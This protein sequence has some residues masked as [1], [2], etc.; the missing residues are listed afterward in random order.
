MY[1][2]INNK[3]H[4]VEAYGEKL[5]YMSNGYPRL[6]DIN[7]A[8]PTDMVTVAEVA[9]VPEDMQVH[10]YCYTDEGGFTLNPDWE[11]PNGYGIPEELLRQ[12]KDDTIAEV[13]GAVLNGID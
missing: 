8:W 11:E 7:T 2:I 6:I 1:L 12:I 4:A 13:E 9:T 3:T 5:D 10:K